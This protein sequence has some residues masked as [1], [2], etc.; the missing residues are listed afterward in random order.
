MGRAATWTGIGALLAA[1]L[2]SPA[3]SAATAVHLD[4][5]QGDWVGQGQELTFTSPG[6]AISTASVFGNS[7]VTVSWGSWRLQ[8][9]S[10][11]TAALA[12]GN[13]EGATRYPFNSNRYPGLSLSGDGRG[14]NRLEGWFEIHEAS[15]A[16]SSV[17]A[18]AADFVQSCDGGPAL[19][20]AVRINSAVPLALPEPYARAAGTQIVTEGESVAIEGFASFDR[21][22]SIAS[23]GWTQDAGTPVTLANA[24]TAVVSFTA[25]DVA[26]GGETLTFTLTVTDTDGHVDLAEVE[27]R[28]RDVGDPRTRAFVDSDA[29]DYIGQGLTYWYD[30]AT[31]SITT[32]GVSSVLNV[33]IDGVEFWTA[34]FALPSGA[35][36]SPG[37]Y[38]GARRYPFQLSSQ[39]GLSFYGEGR[40]CNTLSGWFEIVEVQIVGSSLL[41]LAVDFVQHCEQGATRLFGAIRIN[42]AVP[43][44]REVAYAI[45]APVPPATEGEEVVLDGSASA[46]RTGE[47]TYQ[48][49]QLSGTPVDLMYANS[50]AATFTAPQTAPGGETLT[51]QLTVTDA[52]GLT[53]TQTVSVR[54]HDTTDAR[55]RAYIDSP[56]GD[57]IGGGVERSFSTPTSS[58]TST[59]ANGIVAVAFDGWSVDFEAPAGRTLVPGAGY[60]SVS[61][62]A[63]RKRCAQH[64]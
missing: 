50:L 43:L 16:G 48:W 47:L 9:E 5:P 11:G 57:W 14:C 30:E 39:P 31:A 58:F 52:G 51:F 44:D 21:A 59:A 25:P 3:A 41:R 24:G 40:G 13:Y 35:N 38:A 36:W 7:L 37:I 20:G 12:P 63:F 53:D 28:V 29:G 10:A 60:S 2:V 6:T 15:F 1:W 46:G 62:I 23:Y 42:S 32:G 49:T 56:G 27:V 18:F 54:I 26:P 34:S 61:W 19:F 8:F 55:T 17:L 45:V 64:F 22:T 33:T 4:S